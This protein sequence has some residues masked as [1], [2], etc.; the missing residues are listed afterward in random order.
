MS[1]VVQGSDQTLRPLGLGEVLDRAVTLCVKNFVPLALIFIIYA[2]PYAVVQHLATRD[3]AQL[4]ATFQGAITAQSGKAGGADPAALGHALSS[5]SINGW[6]PLLIVLVFFV[7]PLPAAALIQACAAAYFKRPT[8]LAS[9]YRVAL[10]RWLPLIGINVL[11]LGAGLIL[12]VLVVLL[13][14]AIILG[15]VFLTA[16]LHAVG[17]A[18]AVLIGAAVVLAG[19]AF[20]VVAALAIQISYFTCVL[21]G[22]GTI[23]AFAQ[24][25]RRVFFGVGLARSLLVG[26][27]F[28]AIGIGIGLVALLGQS[29]IVGLSHSTVAGTIYATIVRIAT[30]A[31]TTAF[32]AIFYYDLRVREDGLDLELAADAAR[33]AIVPV[34]T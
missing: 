12:Y 30:A 4:L 21:E 32:I 14:I 17:V 9:A 16:A 26:V 28:F 13:A 24:G 2:I 3:F 18:L 29:I 20:F 15:L 25:L 23:V 8:T 11:Y 6:Y 34:T 5:G 22:A 7:G 19:V 1:E 10:G 31:F 27:A 33:G